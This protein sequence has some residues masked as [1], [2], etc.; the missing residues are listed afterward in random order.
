MSQLSNQT[1][2]QTD[3]YSMTPLTTSSAKPGLNPNQK[4]ILGISAATVLL[5]GAIGLVL[6]RTKD[7]ETGMP[8]TSPTEGNTVTD[9]PEKV[10]V[11]GK[12]TDSMSFEQ[13]FSAA[14]DEVGMGGAFNWHGRWYNTF[15]KEEWSGLSLEQRQDYTEMITGEKL[16][17]KPYETQAAQT[18]EGAPESPTIIEGH[19]NGQ[20]VMGIDFD[21]DGVID[22]LVMEG[23]DGYTYRVVDASGGDGLD[24]L[25]RYD[26]L[27]GE[28]VEIEKIDKPFLLSND[29]FSQ[30]LEESMSKEVVDSILEP[31]ASGTGPATDDLDEVDKSED[32]DTTYLADSHEPDDTYVNNGDVR[33]MDE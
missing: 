16:P 27:N 10:D 22:T 2:L 32:N 21:Q 8:T 12:V 29:Q 7:P 23:A 26:S 33:D 13:A 11:A 6:G 15:E 19:L 31:D 17:V 24:T 30:G 25:F 1:D 4:K 3:T 28:L 18:P 9:L 14:R 5:G 20:R